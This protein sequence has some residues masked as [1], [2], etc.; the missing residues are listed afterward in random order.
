M[1]RNENEIQR[2]HDILVAV[3]RKETP[4]IQIDAM[5]LNALH[6]AADTLCWVLHH[7]Y[8]PAFADNLALIERALGGRFEERPN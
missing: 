3:L 2:A 8:N 7:D 4:P 6:V 5:A 1:T